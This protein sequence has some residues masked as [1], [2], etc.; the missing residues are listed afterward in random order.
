M[1]LFSFTTNP[2]S[3]FSYEVEQ[4]IEAQ[5]SRMMENAIYDKEDGATLDDLIEYVRCEYCDVTNVIGLSVDDRVSVIMS[6]EDGLIP[7]TLSC[8]NLHWD[9]ENASSSVLHLESEQ[10][11]CKSLEDL[12]SFLEDHDFNFDQVSESDPFRH[13]AP[14]SIRNDEGYEVYEYRNC[15]GID[16]EVWHI[17]DLVMKVFVCQEFKGKQIDFEGFDHL[18][19]WESGDW[20][21]ELFDTNQTRNG[22]SRLAYRLFDQSWDEE[23]IFEG[24]NFVNSIL[25]DADSDH[26]VIALLSF[27]A[28]NP[29]DLDDE[30]AAAFTKDQIG[31]LEERSE[32]L[33]ILV[34]DLQSE[35]DAADEHKSE[36]RQ[37][38][39]V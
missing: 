23:A 31:W 2:M 39:S 10:R 8:E 5:A 4:T 1:P 9:I 25:H 32:E 18:R 17:H 36:E 33:G 28:I 14:E 13:F 37:Q 38:G 7:E 11:A 19:T 34:A 30:S 26:A 20:K 24:D 27:L 21:L 6:H 29:N 3:N 16:A 15:D 22:R 35:L 12:A